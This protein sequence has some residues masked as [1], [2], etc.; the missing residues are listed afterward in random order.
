MKS[1]SHHLLLIEL[2][3]FLAALSVL[4]WHYQHFTFVSFEPV[5]LVV[6]EQPFYSV[7]WPFYERGL[8]GVQVFWAVSGFIFFWKY[9]APLAGRLVD[10]RRFFILRF[11]RLYPLHLMTLLL[12]CLLQLVYFSI[13]HGYFVY[14][15][16]DL[17]H[18]IAQLLF[19]SNWLVGD[20]SFNGPIWSVSCE[21]LVYVFFYIYV[22]KLNPGARMTLAVF[23]V[24]VALSVTHMDSNVTNCLKYFLLGGLSFELFDRMRLSQSKRKF[25]LILLASVLLLLL[26]LLLGY[27][28]GVMRFKHYTFILLILIP[29]VLY[30]APMRI[31]VG[32]SLK[33]IIS[34]L[35]NLTYSSY[36]THFPI[37]LVIVSLYSYRGLA[38]PFYD[39]RFFLAYLVIVFAF[40]FL[41]YRYFERPLQN[42]IRGKYL[43]SEN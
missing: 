1:T 20:L 22:T 4:V 10:A 6:S 15:F 12:V 43:L 33:D 3:R 23:L 18:F 39:S 26:L 25:D 30:F 34:G 35:G 11:S 2:V 38:I 24:C 17:G 40:S 7:L 36:L 21:V 37:Q 14:G 31:R 32:D 29:V 41:T 42:A 13:N 27:Q 5:R 8:L 28:L 16:Y 9:K 19:A